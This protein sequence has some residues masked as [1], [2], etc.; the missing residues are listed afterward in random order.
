MSLFTDVGKIKDEEIKQTALLTKIA[1]A[2]F[3]PPPDPSDSE[4]SP[5]LLEIV[6]RTTAMVQTSKA[7]VSR[8]NQLTD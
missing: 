7:L 2:L 4:A 3:A 6:E 1:D 8:L 5:E